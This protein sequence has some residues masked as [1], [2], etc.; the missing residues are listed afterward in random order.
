MLVWQTWKTVASDQGTSDSL[1]VVLLLRDVR[2]ETG[3]DAWSMRQA[4]YK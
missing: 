4:R 2:F 1:C 3:V